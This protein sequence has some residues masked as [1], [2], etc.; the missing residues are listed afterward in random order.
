MPLP[1]GLWNERGKVGAGGNL[2][3]DGG[4]TIRETRF[5]N[6]ALIHITKAAE[7]R[8][9]SFSPARKIAVA[10]TTWSSLFR[11]K[12][13][14]KKNNKALASYENMLA[15]PNVRDGLREAFAKAGFAPVDAARSLAELASGRSKT[16]VTTERETPEGM[17][18]EVKTTEH[19]PNV[20]ALKAYYEMTHEMPSQRTEN[21]NLNIDVMKAT[22]VSGEH[23]APSALEGSPRPVGELGPAQSGEVNVFAESESGA[24][25]EDEDEE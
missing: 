6:A 21:V 10:C 5:I 3:G 15:H 12:E 4:P 14:P 9:T 16:I 8:E 2:A 24:Y 11:M 25:K 13:G 18:H 1:P 17:M 22:P 23:A 20:A 7:N 19:P